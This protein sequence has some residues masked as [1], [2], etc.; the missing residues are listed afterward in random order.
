MRLNKNAFIHQKAVNKW[1]SE[2]YA[3]TLLCFQDIAQ[4]HVF[5]TYQ[6]VTREE[7]SRLIVV[8]VLFNHSKVKQKEPSFSVL[9]WEQPKQAKR[10]RK[11]VALIDLETIVEVRTTRGKLITEFTNGEDAM[12]WCERW[13]HKYVS[14]D[15][16]TR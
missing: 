16:T 11:R 8:T 9:Y 14:I 1:L 7:Q 10:F 3:E 13:R 6:A 5:E 12:N 4:D 15:L 2:T